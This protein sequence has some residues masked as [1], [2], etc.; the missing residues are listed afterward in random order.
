MIEV[1]EGN[2][3]N[4]LIA[5]FHQAC[6]VG[7]T[8]GIQSLCSTFKPYITNLSYV[9]SAAPEVIIIIGKHDT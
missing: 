1:R 7:E 5:N 3:P 2:D 8:E 4:F 6:V 9:R